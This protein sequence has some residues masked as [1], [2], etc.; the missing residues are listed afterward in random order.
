MKIGIEF[1]SRYFSI[2]VAIYSLLNAYLLNFA[3]F[4]KLKKIMTRV[5][6]LILVH[7][8]SIQLLAIF[9][10]LAANEQGLLPKTSKI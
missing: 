4:F 10:K 6:L 9:H 2:N 5:I 3:L 8:G 7:P 1:Y